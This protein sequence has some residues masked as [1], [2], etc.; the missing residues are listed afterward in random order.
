MLGPG[1]GGS[2]S[3]SEMGDTRRGAEQRQSVMTSVLDVIILKGQWDVKGEGSNR[4]LGI[5]TDG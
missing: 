4:P 5:H 1:V 2:V 3:S